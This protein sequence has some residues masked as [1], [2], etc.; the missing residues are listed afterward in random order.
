MVE[1]FQVVSWWHL[2]LHHGTN[3]SWEELCYRPTDHAYFGILKRFMCEMNIKTFQKQQCQDIRSSENLNF[4]SFLPWN[5]EELI[6]V[7]RAYKQIISGDFSEPVINA[8]LCWLL[9]VA[10]VIRP[11]VSSVTSMCTRA[12]CVLNV[13]MWCTVSIRS[14]PSSI[15]IVTSSKT[16][17]LLLSDTS[18]EWS[19]LICLMYCFVKNKHF[20]IF[21]VVHTPPPPPSP[22]S[23]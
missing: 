14:S 8:Q 16:T 6:F 12:V 11:S 17:P 2:A 19:T 5:H 7:Y 3:Q 15:P 21:T 13:G 10:S 1:T 9:F 23:R 22:L 18:G 4:C 20:N